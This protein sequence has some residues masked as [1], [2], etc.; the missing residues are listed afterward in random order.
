MAFAG[1][2]M[3]TALLCSCEGAGSV[4]DNIDELQFVTF[5]DTDPLADF[6]ARM[7]QPRLS[8]D[9]DGVT[10]EN[11]ADLFSAMSTGLDLKAI[12]EFRWFAEFHECF[13]L[14]VL[15]H[16]RAV[17][18]NHWRAK[19]LAEQI[20]W[21]FDLGSIG[22]S[23]WPRRTADSHRYTD[24]DLPT[25]EFRADGF[26]IET[27]DWYY[28]IHL[29][30]IADFDG[31]GVADVLATFVDHAKQA[32]Y[33]DVSPIILNHDATGTVIRGKRVIWEVLEGSLATW[34]DDPM[35]CERGR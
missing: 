31:D 27:E 8:S 35:T 14:P 12:S 13:E 7:A 21:R 34:P 22:S 16:A 23:L 29:R 24:F 3:I 25:P 33:F 28:G 26:M 18:D 20:Y 10:I 5:G 6:E 30:A 19:G 1:G 15:C 11:C 2:L 4:S 17:A 32:T 9:V